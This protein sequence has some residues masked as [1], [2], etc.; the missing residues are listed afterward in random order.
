[1]SAAADVRAGDTQ[2][3]AGGGAGVAAAAAG[4]ETARE[5]EE[6]VPESE[7]KPEPAAKRARTAWSPP[8]QPT[9]PPSLQRLLDQSQLGHPGVN[10]EDVKSGR[11]GLVRQLKR[12]DPYCQ[13]FCLPAAEANAAI[14]AIGAVR[15]D[16]EASLLAAAGAITT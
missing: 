8:E 13:D 11:Q 14:V 12:R 15:S 4:E 10:V 2:E 7:S 16:E 1:S 9:L 3:E 6:A 5:N